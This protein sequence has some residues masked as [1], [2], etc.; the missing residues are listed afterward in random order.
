MARQPALPP[1]RNGA[2]N[3]RQNPGDRGVFPETERC[4]GQAIVGR[5]TGRWRLELRST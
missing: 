2:L 5:A 3:Q 1:R 4:T